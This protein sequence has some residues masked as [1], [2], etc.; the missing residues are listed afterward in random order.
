MQLRDAR[1][2]AGLDQGSVAE[3]MAMSQNSVSR[4]ENGR[5]LPSAEFIELYARAVGRP[6]R[7]LFGSVAVPEPAVRLERAKRALVWAYDRR[8]WSNDRIFSRELMEIFRREDVDDATGTY[9]RLLSRAVDDLGPYL[10]STHRFKTAVAFAGACCE[11]IDWSRVRTELAEDKHG[12][13]SMRS[14]HARVMKRVWDVVQ[15]S[16]EGRRCRPR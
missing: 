12:R 7:L 14:V 6:I 8:N 10:T 16:A 15:A 11:A 1:R 3:R 4:V 5:V 13:D 2:E 9:I